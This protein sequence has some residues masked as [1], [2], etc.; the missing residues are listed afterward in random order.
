MSLI[1]KYYENSLITPNCL[2]S[3]N[4]WK[5]WQMW[6]S[7]YDKINNKPQEA[8]IQPTALPIK[9]KRELD[10]TKEF[11][12]SKYEKIPN[13]D[14]LERN[15]SD[16]SLFRWVFLSKISPYY[17]ALSENLARAMK[18][19]NKDILSYFKIDLGVYRPNITDEMKIYFNETF[20]E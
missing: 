8:D 13:V 16:G 9:L 20:R 19:K 3:A 15:L 7:K 18:N 2:A 6:K 17:I 14:D 11:L 5:R 10:T 12:L 1:L 4:S